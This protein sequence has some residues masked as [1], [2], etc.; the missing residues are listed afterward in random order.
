MN[1]DGNARKIGTSKKKKISKIK[2]GRREEAGQKEGEGKG[3]E[4]KRTAASSKA[5]RVNASGRS[6]RR[7]RGL[8]YRARWDNR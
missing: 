7:G 4:E 3:R 8:G 5:E 6:A 2:G 1:A